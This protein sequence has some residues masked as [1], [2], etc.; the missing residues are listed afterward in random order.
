MIGP[1][2]TPQLSGRR[3]TTKSA[4]SS[5]WAHAHQERDRDGDGP[6][7]SL[8]G[9]S[10]PERAQPSAVI[11]LAAHAGLGRVAIAVADDQPPALR[12]GAHSPYGHRDWVRERDEIE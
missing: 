4:I 10:V 2:T 6:G 7:G 11:L 9:P 1:G 12:S 3:K 5:I 8:V